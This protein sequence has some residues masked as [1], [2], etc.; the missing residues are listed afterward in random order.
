MIRGKGEEVEEEE[1]EEEEEEK[2]EEEKEEER[3][4]HF[5]Y[6]KSHLALPTATTPLFGWVSSSSSVL[7]TSPDYQ[8]FSYLTQHRRRAIRF[9][10]SGPVARASRT[11]RFA[12]LQGRNLR[13]DNV[14]RGQE[15]DT[16]EIRT[17]PRV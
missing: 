5:D 11:D 3:R 16:K 13:L 4:V 2:E 17:V 14:R 6:R 1:E 9:F 10:V 8:S 15:E 12:R 7:E